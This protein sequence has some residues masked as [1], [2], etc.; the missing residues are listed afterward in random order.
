MT[1]KGDLDPFQT[2]KNQMGQGSHSNNIP[3]QNQNLQNI[4]ESLKI[5]KFRQEIRKLKFESWSMDNVDQIRFIEN[6][7]SLIS[8][9]YDKTERYLLYIS[10]GAFIV[11]IAYLTASGFEISTMSKIYLVVS[12]ISF[13]LTILFVILTF[14][15]TS[16]KLSE[17][18]KQVANKLKASQNYY[19]QNLPMPEEHEFKVDDS[20]LDKLNNI[21]F[22]SFISGIIFLLLFAITTLFDK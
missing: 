12:W 3:N 1:K 17:L 22:Y 4:I 19:H 18:S 5:E 13:G 14:S 15:H 16:K 2:P 8:S 21:A 10:S 11:S 20:N 6:L 9:N 7:R